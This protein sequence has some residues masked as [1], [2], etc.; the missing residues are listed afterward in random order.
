MLHK[1]LLELARPEDFTGDLG[2]IV[3]E[4]GLEVA[5]KLVDKLGGTQLNIPRSG[6]KATVERYVRAQ[7]NGTNA[8]TLALKCGITER[9]VYHIVEGGAVKGDQ[10]TFI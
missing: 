6:L 8:K 2:L 5:V 7:Y 9:H 3:Q 10:H 4:C 1:D